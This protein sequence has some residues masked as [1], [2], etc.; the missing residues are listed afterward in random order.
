MSEKKRF[1]LLI[2]LLALSLALFA[3]AKLHVGPDFIR[4][5]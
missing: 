4:Q 3:W 2:V 5:L 1:V